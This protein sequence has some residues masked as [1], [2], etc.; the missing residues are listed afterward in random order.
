MLLNRRRDLRDGGSRRAQNGL[1]EALHVLMA[2]AQ[3][4]I[5]LSIVVL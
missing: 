4:R 5:G 1:I 2:V 3:E